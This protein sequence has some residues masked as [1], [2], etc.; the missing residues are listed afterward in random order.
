MRDVKD[1]FGRV[2]EIQEFP[3]HHIVDWRFGH[4]GVAGA[5]VSAIDVH[6]KLC[7]SRRARAIK[8]DRCAY[9]LS[10]K[11]SNRST[12]LLAHR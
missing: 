5:M 12:Q 3:E 11:L 6:G 8:L 9:A 7:T 2:G 10:A 1:V 4:G